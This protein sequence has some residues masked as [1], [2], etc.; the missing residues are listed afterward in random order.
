MK[1]YCVTFSTTTPQDAAVKA[2]NKKE[3]IEKVL[4]VIPDAYEIAVW[5]VRGEEGHVL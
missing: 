2:K 5:E 3:A 4:E 1:R